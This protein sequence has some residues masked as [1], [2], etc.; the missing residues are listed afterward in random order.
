M[1]A[2]G[3]ALACVVVA[4]GV[5]FGYI[6]ADREVF[7]GVRALEFFNRDQIPAEPKAYPLANRDGKVDRMAPLRTELADIDPEPK[8]LPR[9][10]SLR[11]SYAAVDPVATEPRPAAEAP[12][13]LPK[14]RPKAQLLRRQQASYTLL[15]DLQIDAIR[16]RLKLTA[17]QE[18]NWPALEGALRGLATRLHDMK[19]S[20]EAPTDLAPDSDELAKLKAAATPFIAQ[21]TADQKRELRTL[22]HLIGLGKIVAQ[23]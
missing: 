22:A 6:A 14:P 7:A 17:E 15:S 20:G 23:L 1:R 16:T 10:D 5:A 11:Q 3:L 18:R 12:P 4:G 2:A 13:P 8:L 21:L 19:K 9:G